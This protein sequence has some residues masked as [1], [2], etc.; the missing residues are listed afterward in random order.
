MAFTGEQG[1]APTGGGGGRD[2]DAEGAYRGEPYR[3]HLSGDD[4]PA[5]T[6]DSV[7]WHVRATATLADAG[8]SVDGSLRA[9]HNP[10]SPPAVLGSPPKMS[11]PEEARRAGLSWEGLPNPKPQLTV[12]VYSPRGREEVYY[13]GPHAPHLTPKE[14][15]LLHKI[16][17][18]CSQR[19]EPEEVHHHDIIHFA[20]T[21]IA[22]RLQ[23][24][25]DSE[26]LERLRS[27]LE[28]MKSRRV[29][30]L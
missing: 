29:P 2:R 17:L 11:A 21:E 10:Q 19:L 14:I 28:E 23:E 7:P 30:H 9:V 13:L 27:H 8:I 26:V 25:R 15:D 1:L 24:G 6:D 12:E 5:L 4:L 3:V 22:Q 16:W 18:E 20:L